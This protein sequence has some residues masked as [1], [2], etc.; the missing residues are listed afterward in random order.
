MDSEAL[1]GTIKDWIAGKIF[2]SLPK[3]LVQ[4]FLAFL[5]DD[6]DMT[7]HVGF[8]ENQAGDEFTLLLYKSDAQKKRKEEQWRREVRKPQNQV[9]PG[10][11]T[12]T[13]SFLQ[14]SH[15]PKAVG[16]YENG[17]PPDQNQNSANQSPTV[18]PNLP[19]NLDMQ[20]LYAKTSA[21]NSN[22][23]QKMM[24]QDQPQM[25]KGVS[26]LSTDTFYLYADE[27]LID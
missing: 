12:F 27:L 26:E 8:R 19:N 20:G 15:K 24:I 9:G 6:R 10:L 4:K 16:I 5:L 22:P 3:R 25:F 1:P 18:L 23:N 21:S 2:K 14:A 17:L 13:D 11:R 7:E